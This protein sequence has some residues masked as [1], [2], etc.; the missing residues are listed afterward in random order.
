MC[1]TMQKHLAVLQLRERVFLMPT[2]SLLSRCCK[3]QDSLMLGQT[4]D[5]EA[6]GLWRFLELGEES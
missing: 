3:T 5:F 6:Q 4:Y 2:P 1:Q